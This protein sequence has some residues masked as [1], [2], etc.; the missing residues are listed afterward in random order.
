MCSLERGWSQPTLNGQIHLFFLTGTRETN[1]AEIGDGIPSRTL[2][3]VAMNLINIIGSGQ[4]RVVPFLTLRLL[5]SYS[6]LVCNSCVAL[7]FCFG[8]QP[9]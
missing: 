5:D 4:F 8:V 9:S 2:I 7:V 3:E 1:L 6:I